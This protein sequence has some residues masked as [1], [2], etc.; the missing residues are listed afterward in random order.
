MRISDWSSDVCS[1]DL[2]VK[3]AFGS[4]V[5]ATGDLQTIRFRCLPGETCCISRC[6]RCCCRSGE[7]QGLCQS[8]GLVRNGY[9]LFESVGSECGC[10]SRAC[11]TGLK[12]IVERFRATKLQRREAMSA[13]GY[14]VTSGPTHER[15]DIGDRTCVACGKEGAR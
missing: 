15:T 5:R 12:E 7:R 4:K 2:I 3:S 10:I 11:Q 13:G 9:R 6:S 14:P 1:S 8:E